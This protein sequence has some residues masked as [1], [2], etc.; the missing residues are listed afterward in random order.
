MKILFSS[1]RY[2][3][4]TPVVLFNQLNEEFFFTLDPCCEQHNAKCDKYFTSKQDGLRQDWQGE[5]VFCNP[6]Y[7]K[8]IYKWV[9]KC[10]Q[11]SR[12]K[13][14]KVVMLIPS[15]T[16]TKYFHEFIYNVANEIRFLKGRLRFSNSRHAAPFPSMIVIF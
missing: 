15:R 10:F 9:E 1:Q 6:P 7:G 2:D 14:T 3:W 13:N 12:K 8:A 11:E 5:T 4:E 16:D